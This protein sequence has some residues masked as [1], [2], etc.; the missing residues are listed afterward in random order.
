MNTRIIPH[1]LNQR[2][3]LINLL[4]DDGRCDDRVLGEALK[5]GGNVVSLNE[6][7]LRGVVAAA[8]QRHGGEGIPIRVVLLRGLKG[9]EKVNQYVT[10]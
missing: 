5:H 9:K 7:Q 8:G 2:T 10:W 3:H 6:L 1:K 4:V